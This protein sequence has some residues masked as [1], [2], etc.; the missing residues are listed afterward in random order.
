MH[1]MKYLR[2]L[3]L[4]TMLFCVV[5][6]H[7]TSY[8]YNGINYTLNDND[9]TAS[10]TRGSYSGSIVIPSIV[11]YKYTVTSIECNAFEK[12]DN[13][14][15]VS[16]PNTLTSIDIFAFSGCSSLTSVIIGSDVTSINSDAFNG[17]NNLNKVTIKCTTPP[18]ISSGTFTN[19]ANATL[20]IPAGSK[21]AYNAANYWKEFK[22]TVEIVDFADANVKA[23]C[24]ANWDTNGDG[25]L[26][27]KEAAAVKSFGTI[28][29]GNTSI[30]KFGEMR[31]FTGLGRID[32][33]AF[34]GCTG[35]TSIE[36]P[37]GILSIGVAAF[38][39]CK[40]LES[41]T[42]PSTLN[43]IGSSAFQGCEKL[44]S[45]DI[46]NGTTRIDGAA[47]NGCSGLKT[48][49]IPQSITTIGANAFEGCTGRLN[50]NC[51]IPNPP[52]YDLGVFYGAQFTEVVMGD[53]VKTIGWNAFGR[54][55]N[56]TLKSVTIGKNVVSIGNRAFFQNSALTSINIPNSVKTI[57][58]QVFFR[59]T[60]LESVTIG[61][62][63]ESMG[64]GVFQECTALE[65]ANIQSGSIGSSAFANCTNLSSLT[66]GN[67]VSSISEQAF[68]HCEKLSVVDIPSSVKTIDRVAFY[69]C[70]GLTSIT[71]PSS[72]T[73]IGEWAFGYC[74]GKAYINRNITTNNGNPYAGARFTEV[75]VGDGVTEI[76]NDAFREMST[77]TSISLP[78]G[79][80]TIGNNAFFSCNGLTSVKIPASV[81]SIGSQAFCNS[82]KMNLA[83]GSVLSCE[84]GDE[85]FAGC[86]NLTAVTF[87]SNVG[88]IGT[89]AF[90]RCE[91]L[92][93]ATVPK[94]V[95][96]MKTIG[97]YAFSECSKMAAFD[98]PSCVDSIG[99]GA[100]EKCSSLTSI[101]LP[102]G[103]RTIVGNAFFG[104]SGVTS[105][106][107][108]ESVK[109]M[110]SNIFNGC[111]GT[112]Y[113]Y[114]NLPGYSEWSSPFTAAKFSSIVL[115]ENVTE[116]SNWIFYQCKQ[117]R[118][119]TVER[120]TPVEIGGAVFP[121][122]SSSTLY[123]PNGGKFKYKEADY[124]KE[125]QNIVA[126]QY[127]LT[128]E[129]DGKVYKTDSIDFE[130]PLVALKGP[131]KEGYTFSGWSE[132]PSTMPAQDVV[133]TGTFSINKYLL[134]YK[135]DGEVYKSDSIVFNSA[136]TAIV[137]P[138]KE[139]YT[140]SGW[141]EIPETMPA[142]NVVVTGSFKINK[143]LLTYKVDDEVFK[144]DSIVYNSSL[145]PIAAPTKEGY[146]FSGW[147]EI[148]STMPAQDVV[149]TGS[150]KINKY[151]L[152]YQVDDEIVK[153]DSIV[154]NATITP[155]AEP[156]KEGYT[157]S[158]WS[159]IPATMPAHDIVVTGTFS[160]N[161]YLLTYKVDGEVFKSDSIIYNS[162][163]TPITEPTKEGYTFSGWSEIPET[164][165]AK[166]VLVTGSFSINK[167]LL[168]YK[169]DDEVFKSDSIVYNSA[170]TAI[171]EPTKEGY[172]FSGWS[173]IPDTMP[174]QDVVVTGI[175]SINSYKLTYII[176]DKVYKDTVYEYG[177]TIVPEPI[178]E[179]NYVTFE[180]ID[181]P[182]T[183]PAHDVVVHASYTTG[184]REIILAKPQDV[185]IYSP[186]GKKLNKLQK[187]LN[188]VKM[189][190]GTIRKIV[191]K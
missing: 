104:C 59:C 23:I 7:A 102:E 63:L 153:S 31:H 118:N 130:A 124:W 9:L 50:I 94:D 160:I 49:S 32:D 64:S 128:Y 80:L 6:L 179:G 156:T 21:S 122:R 166:D 46:P 136:L 20:Y 173:E 154:Y 36:I 111:Q 98:F 3:F 18:T 107:I 164:M 149:V 69:E 115:G 42:L 162:S 76:G 28:F 73:S 181:L 55:G 40:N 172:T 37:E 33:S 119:V 185:Q 187:G 17:C 182:E 167:Y 52:H 12:C 146:T 45:I 169:V 82:K 131:T 22:E 178:P 109:E 26:Y 165:P 120:T 103:L 141:S 163:L 62:G 174:A 90:A 54:D 83:Q 91:A 100:F 151:L 184:I 147:S 35:L 30:T 183:M 39:D 116:I 97:Q 5:G 65:S 8:S 70:S 190:D 112:A 1:P 180:W 142:E 176:D 114:C 51:N 117:L 144:S 121:Y 175:F 58:N 92:A 189:R 2:L 134:T 48:M 61:N 88:N 89:S 123:C 132:I 99:Y 125:F 143:Y 133:I 85:A 126:P 95:T 101:N 78:D 66:L 155:E 47:F 113:I 148:P 11:N 168:T 138:T 108:P 14:T 188:I 16:L 44:A 19:R 129:V 27:P 29:M 24:V 57:G 140:F 93:S 157:F 110:G 43:S 41:V 71:I 68:E 84:I 145:T 86:T 96:K 158:G 10:V 15:S 137:E 161:K 4:L 135:V 67:G 75:F 13:L 25:E 60:S 170:L 191:V 105:V 139:G 56:N 77:L 87:G 127:K 150:F 53:S 159:E 79:L 152:T 38:Q 74:T 81:T 177:A 34:Q 171:E 186:N 106:T 72:V